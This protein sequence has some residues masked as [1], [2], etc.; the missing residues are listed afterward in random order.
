LRTHKAHAR[1]DED[2]IDSS[3]SPKNDASGS[4][5][6]KDSSLNDLDIKAFGTFVEQVK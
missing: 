3:F 1:L 2:A 5:E 6:G 4:H